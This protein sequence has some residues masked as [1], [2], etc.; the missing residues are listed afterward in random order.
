MSASGIVFDDGDSYEKMM[1]AWSSEAGHRFLEWLDPEPNKAWLDVGC[2]TGAFAGLVA[3][4]SSPS[5]VIGVDPSPDQ[6]AAAIQNHGMKAHFL[7]GDAM[8]LQFEAD[9]FDVA[10]MA[11]VI[12]FLPEPLHGVREMAR[13]VKP[14]GTVGSYTWDALGK[15]GPTRVISEELAKLDVQLPRAP[16]PE[17]SRME[18]LEETWQQAGLTD[19]RKE[20]IIVTRKFD[21]FENYW[22]NSWLSP[23]LSKAKK[24]VSPDILAEA[25]ARVR[26]HVEMGNEV[27]ISATANA[28]IGTVR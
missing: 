20:E 16:N 4:S 27:S 1:G 17:I 3:R 7:V 12:F 25:K 2:G 26:K 10:I 22:T 14:G 6:I 28:I 13:V 19:I 8:A 23:N 9:Q 5:S 15:G 11:L 24:G 18:A 21:N